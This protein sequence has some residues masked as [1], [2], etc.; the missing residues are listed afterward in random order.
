MTHMEASKITDEETIKKINDIKKI[1]FENINKK[2]NFLDINATCLLNP[3]LI[4]IGKNTLIPN[5]VKKGKLLEK[6]PVRIVKNSS[7][8]Y[9]QIRI[10]SNYKKGKLNLKAGEEYVCDSKLLKKINEKAWKAIIK[11]RNNFKM[12][13]NLYYLYF[14]I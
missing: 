4:L 14:N 3:K 6:I 1:E 5:F 2:R 11:K 8:G 13:F 7:Y 12:A 9:Y 10:S